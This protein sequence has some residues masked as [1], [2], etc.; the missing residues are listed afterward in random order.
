MLLALL[1]VVFWSTAP[2]AFK[3]GL[4]YQDTYQLLTGAS[5]GSLGALTLILVLRRQ[6][7]PWKGLSG[8]DVSYSLVLGLIN[9]V[10]Y[11]LV[12]FKAYSLLPAQVAQPLNMVWP[13]VLVLLSVPFLRQK[14]SWL[15]LAAMGI[16]FLGVVLISWQGG[17][18]GQEEGNRLGVFLALGTSLLRS[19]Y[20]VLNARDGKDP[21]VRLWLN[22]FFASLVL[23]AG[24]WFRSPGL[25]EGWEA[26]GTAV[27]VGVFEMGVTFVLWLTALQKAPSTDRISNLVYLA[28]FLNL[29]W[30]RLFLQEHIFPGTLAG[31]VLL[32]AGILLQ[33]T[34]GRKKHG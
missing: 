21:V 14:L 25:P 9:P 2:T 12:L 30:I 23:L 26:W 33:N 15:S 6:H 18:L 22:F 13:L 32:V 29:F 24:C 31:L 10:V 1:A 7:R 20:W 34:L 4:R 17:T 11:Y 5:L 27:Y 3:L 8:R 16:S 19:L 28:P